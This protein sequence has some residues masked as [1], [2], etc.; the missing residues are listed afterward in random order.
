MPFLAQISLTS[1]D[2]ELMWGTLESSY[3]EDLH[4]WVLNTTFLILLQQCL[5]T[6]SWIKHSQPMDPQLTVPQLT[7]VHERTWCPQIFNSALLHQC[8]RL[9]SFSWTGSLALNKG[10]NLHQVSTKCFSLPPKL[11]NQADRPIW[12]RKGSTSLRWA[13]KMTKWKDAR[14]VGNARN[15]GL[16]GSGRWEKREK[17]GYWKGGEKWKEMKQ[18]NEWERNG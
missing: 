4:F 13:T 17:A 14:W 16:W 15:T 5:F 9:E 2:I 18:N 8:T 1:Y 11:L 10:Q 7:S 12:H 6:S 3:E